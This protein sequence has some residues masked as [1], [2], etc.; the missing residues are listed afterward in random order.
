MAYKGINFARQHLVPVDDGNL[1]RAIF[2]DGSLHGCQISTSG[3]VLTMT[4]GYIMCGGRQIEITADES[5]TLNEQTSGY[6][7]IL[8]QI[9][10]TQ[11]A[12]ESTFQQVSTLIQYAATEE[13][14]ATLIQQ[15][16]N[17]GGSLYQMQLALVSLAAG[18]ISAIV[19]DLPVADLRGGG[20]LNFSI[21]G[22]TTQP[23]GKENL[24][25]VNT[26]TAITSWE[27]S[28]TEP[29]SPVEGMVWFATGT[30]AN[31]PINAIKKNGIWIYP[32]NSSQYIGGEW[33][34]KTSKTYQNGSWIDWALYLYLLG[35]E[36]I[37][38]TNGWQNRAWA[39]GSNYATDLS[40]STLTRN[41]DNLRCYFKSTRTNIY[42]SVVFEIKNDVDVSSYSNLCID[43][44]MTKNNDGYCS[45]A[46]G[47][48]NASYSYTN[49]F[50]VKSLTPSSSRM[51]D[52]LPINNVKGFCD[53]YM[54]FSAGYNG[55]V[56]LHVYKMWLE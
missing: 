12:T 25:W 32:T 53:V 52:R 3:A 10:L 56:D 19:E 16:I 20:G 29:T 30:F 40:Y 49:A 31:A 27:F 28:A 26:N 45:I 47:D 54:P 48:R 9:D 39:W 8:L 33:A 41:N 23:T 38:V 46:V 4:A 2:Q 55:S 22:G 18:G 6:A 44:T 43:Y 37:D 17:N 7:R 51:I 24:I 34:N 21:V 13:G 1:Y 36:F 14:F 50:A 15:D 11:T 42:S 5:F 35:D